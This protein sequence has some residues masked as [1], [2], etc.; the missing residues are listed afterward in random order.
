VVETPEN[1]VLPSD[2]SGCHSGQLFGSAWLRAALRGEPA[3][4]VSVKAGGGT[5]FGAHRCVLRARST[6]L[7]GLLQASPDGSR[8]LDLRSHSSL[9]VNALLEYLYCDYCQAAA[10]VAGDLAPLAEELGLS[11]LHA[12]IG[13]A[14]T[15][16]SDGD[17]RWV[18]TAA[19]V[20]TQVSALEDEEQAGSSLLLLRRSRYADDLAALI[21]HDNIETEREGGGDDCDH[22]DFVQL[23]L[24]HA[25]DGISMSVFVARTLLRS[26]SFFRVLLDGD[27]AEAQSHRG[28]AGGGVVELSTENP[29]ALVLCLKMWALGETSVHMPDDVGLILSLIV[30]AHR[31]CMPGIVAD[32]ELVLCF[33]AADGSADAEVRQALHRTAVL[34]DMPKLLSQLTTS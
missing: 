9:V 1:A 2:L 28:A 31:L 22:Y 6:K 7:A 24:R 11:R 4:D 8:E 5:E 19:G 23:F 3:Y 34:Y 21:V 30:E 13:L 10:N 20:W 16:K 33:L 29:T 18:R 27:F 12:G 14:T 26:I 32:A 17:S 15:T 25:E